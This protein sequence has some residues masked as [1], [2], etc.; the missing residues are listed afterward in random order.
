MGQ[1]HADGLKWFLIDWEDATTHLM[2]LRMV[3]QQ[4]LIFGV[5][6]DTCEALDISPDFR[7]LGDRICN[8]SRELA[9]EEVLILVTRCS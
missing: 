2:F 8:E 5:V 6:V 7:A 3:M 1:C 4:R 9:T